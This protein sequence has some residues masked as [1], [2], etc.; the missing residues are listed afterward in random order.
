MKRTPST[1]SNAFGTMVSPKQHKITFAV[2]K[3]NIT[4]M[5]RSRYPVSFIPVS[6]T[7]SALRLF[8]ASW[9]TLEIGRV[10]LRSAS[11]SVPV[12]ENDPEELLDP[13]C[14]SKEVV[15]SC[16]ISASGSSVGG[17]SIALEGRFSFVV[18]GITA[19]GLTP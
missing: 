2:P 12:I 15:I 1:H 11:T 4:P 6:L 19:I 9:S 10:E 8:V 3:V 7:P 17:S 14:R 16:S 5:L 18:L 13:E